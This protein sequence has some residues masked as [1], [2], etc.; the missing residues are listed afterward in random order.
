[1]SK[2]VV[3]VVA[4]SKGSRSR[5]IG[6]GRGRGKEVLMRLGRW[7]MGEVLVR[8]GRWKM[9]RREGT[10]MFERGVTLRIFLSPLMFQLKVETLVKLLILLVSSYNQLQLH[11]V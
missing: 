11:D 8:V 5:S 3:L 2:V 7:K 10:S 6:R 9:G 4:Y 1:M